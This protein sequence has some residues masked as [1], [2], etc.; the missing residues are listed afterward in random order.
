MT[1]TDRAKTLIRGIAKATGLSPTEV[2]RAF[3]D[4]EMFNSQNPHD[5]ANV[6]ALYID[7]DFDTK[8]GE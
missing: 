2:L 3:A 8:E 7:D 6:A 5:K 4:L 1:I